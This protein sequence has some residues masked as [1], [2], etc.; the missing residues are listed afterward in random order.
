[1]SSPEMQKVLR[2]LFALHDQA[3]ANPSLGDMRAGFDQLWGSYASLPGIDPVPVSAGGVPAAWLVA[4]DAADDRVIVYLHG[5][6]FRVGSIKS[7][8]AITSR[9]SEAPKARVLALDYR[10]APEHPFPAQIDDTVAAYTWL[11]DQGYTPDHMAI[12]GD[13]AGGGLVITSMLKLRDLGLA[14]PA[15]AVSISPWTD[16]VGDG[17]WRDADPSLD[18]IASSPMLD[19]IIADYLVGEDPRQGLVSPLFADLAGLP[20]LLIQVGT[21]EILLNDSTRLAERAREAGV[22]VTLEIEEGAFHVWHH[23]APIVPEARAAIVRI[24][25]FVLRHTG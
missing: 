11:L 23:T 7:H 13:S 18:P 8:A 15:C 14:L 4:P 21:Q 10:L 25:A 12:V 24:G 17:G 1:M 6:G 2:Q 16:L 5:G 3:P 20:P 19:E 22:D 9:L